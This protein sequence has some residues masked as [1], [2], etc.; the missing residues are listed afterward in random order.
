MKYFN[1]I[2]TMLFVAALALVMNGCAEEDNPATPPADDEHK[3]PTTMVVVLKEIGKSDSTK[4]LVR[5]TTLV[6]GKPMVEDT[7]RVI[8]GKSYSGYILLWNESVTPTEDA[9]HEIE[10]EKNEHLFVFTATGN[11]NGRLSITGLEKDDKGNDFGL[12]FTASVAGSGAAVG[13]LR[14]QLRHYGSSPK[15]STVYDTDI[16]KTFPVAIQ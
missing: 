10:G 12:T 3:P 5:D 6:K 16:D 2:R 9:T 14:I 8:S 15:S 7:L 11:A 4:S 1:I 13:G